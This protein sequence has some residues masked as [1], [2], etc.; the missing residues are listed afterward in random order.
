MNKEI[1]YVFLVKGMF[2]QH[3]FYIKQLKRVKNFRLRPDTKKQFSLRVLQKRKKFRVFVLNVAFCF[4]CLTEFLIQMK[5][6]DKISKK[7]KKNCKNQ[8]MVK[9]W[10]KNIGV[11]NKTARI[12]GQNPEC[13]DCLLFRIK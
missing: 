13:S 12:S 8:N 10:K 2:F 11:R 3:S 7:R 5:N 9:L 4:E 6:I 1:S